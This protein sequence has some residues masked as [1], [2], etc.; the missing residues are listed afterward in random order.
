MRLKALMNLPTPNR[1]DP[2]LQIEAAELM[3]LKALMDL[4]TPN[5]GDPQLIVV[6]G[7]MVG[8]TRF[9]LVTP[10]L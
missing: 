4:P 10:C 7:L 8:I 3:R 2:K 6:R 9:E 5:R 1:G